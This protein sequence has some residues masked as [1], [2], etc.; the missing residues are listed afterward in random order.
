MIISYP[1]FHMAP[2]YPPRNVQV[3]NW[4]LDDYGGD[5]TDNLRQLLWSLECE[6]RLLVKIYSYYDGQVLAKYRVMIMLPKKLGLKGEMPAGEARCMASAYQIVVA[7]AITM[8]RGH[9]SQA[10][11]GSTHTI[12]PHET[13]NSGP[14]LDHSTLVQAEPTLVVEYMDRYRSLLNT[15][16]NTH[17]VLV[18][19]L[20]TVIEDFTNPDKAMAR[21]KKLDKEARHPKYI[22]SGDVFE[23]TEFDDPNSENYAY[24]QND[25]KP[26]EGLWTKYNSEQ[27]EW[28]KVIPNKPEPNKYGWEIESQGK[29]IGNPIPCDAGIEEETNYNHREPYGPYG[30]NTNPINLEEYSNSYYT[31]IY[32]WIQEKAKEPTY[33]EEALPENPN[34]S[35]E[36]Y[37]NSS[38]F[39]MTNLSLST[40]NQ[41]YAPPGCSYAPEGSRRTSRHHG[42]NSKKH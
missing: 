27:Q 32:E 31:N 10:L 12:I 22:P 13:S 14:Q 20:D 41:D 23:E 18:H 25:F 28:N 21:R 19:Q 35:V 26:P 16:H 11:E 40:S 38:H 1:Q 4:T 15:Y 5:W 7:A 29:T 42:R 3:M 8:I 6:S 2:R 36:D 39:S 37:A 24:Y 17:Q 30:G 9:K 34:D 33:Y